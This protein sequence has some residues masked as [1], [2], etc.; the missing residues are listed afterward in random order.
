MESV[1]H[2]EAQEMRK[3]LRHFYG[4]LVDTWNINLGVYEVLGGLITSSRQ[5][6]DAMHLVPRPWDL[7]NP[8]KWTRRQVRQAVVRYLNSPQ[9]KYYVIC[10]KN[11][12]KNFRTEFERVQFGF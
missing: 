1:T 5:C 6:T 2:E 10:M 11:A 9:G 8:V 3:V 7:S 4:P 12:A